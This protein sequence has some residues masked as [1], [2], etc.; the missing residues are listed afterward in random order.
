MIYGWRKF[1]VA[2]SALTM[3]FIL[4]FVKVVDGGE[5]VAAVGLIVGLYGAASAAGKFAKKNGGES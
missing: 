4:G 5:W 1:I 3:S 2:M